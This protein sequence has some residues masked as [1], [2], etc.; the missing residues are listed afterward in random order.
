MKE[1]S[2][3]IFL[4]RDHVPE[5]ECF[6]SK[7]DPLYNKI[8]PH[9]TL[10]FPFKS[11]LTTEICKDHIITIL[12]GFST[13]ELTLR[14]TKIAEDGCL[15]LLVDQGKHQIEK[16][17][18]ALH[19]GILS[20]YKSTEHTYEP[21]VTIGRFS[22]SKMAEEAQVSVERFFA[23]ISII[24]VEITLETIGVDDKTQIEYVYE[25]NRTKKV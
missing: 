13:F 16:M 15:Y 9:I 23:P 7:H 21:H 5:I 2:I 19:H 8:P 12:K 14:E 6:R 1:R 4:E 18:N 22:N 17:H 3:G 25:L 24:V 11:T 10:V 20:P